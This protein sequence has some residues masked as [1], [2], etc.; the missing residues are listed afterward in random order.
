MAVT[1]EETGRVSERLTTDHV[2]SAAGVPVDPGDALPVELPGIPTALSSRELSYLHW[3]ASTMTGAGRVVELGSFLGGSTAALVHGLAHS[4]AP[5]ERVLAYDMF[6]V[7]ESAVGTSAAFEAWLVQFGLA[8]GASFLDRFK[9]LHRAWLDRIAVR[10]VEFPESV[11]SWEDRSLYPEQSPIELLFVDVAKSW[12]VHRTVMG[13]F[14]AHVLPGGVLVQQDFMDV[15]TPWIP[16][17]MYQLRDVFEPL[18]AVR[19]TPTVSFRCVGDASSVRDGVRSLWPSS[20]YEDRAARESMWSAVL[21]YWEAAIGAVRARFV[22][23]HAAVHAMLVGDEGGSLEHARVYEEWIRSGASSECY[24]TDA[25]S[26]ILVESSVRLPSLTELGAASLVRSRQRHPFGV[27][28]SAVQF[29]P[30]ELRLK[31]WDRVFESL[32][33]AGHHRVALYG[34]GRHTQ[35]LIESML[36][37]A[38]VEV[39]CVLDDA[40]AVSDIGGIPVILPSEAG[41]ALARVTAV[42][43]SS[44]ADEG[45]IADRASELF[46]D[47]K[48]AV[49]RVY[50]VGEVRGEAAHRASLQAVPS[51]MPDPIV[52]DPSDASAVHR[53]RLGLVR[54]R[55]WLDRFVRVY[56]PPAWARGFVP[57]RDAL[58]LWDMVEAV[59]PDFVLEVGTA[60]GVSSATLIGA[61]HALVGPESSLLTC[62]TQAS[63][64]FD[65]AR[66]VG[67]A[68]GEMVPDLSSRVTVEPYSNA[69]DAA[70]AVPPG[71]ISF[72]FIDA[73]HRHPEPVIDLL[74]LS[75]VLAPGAWVVLH[76]IQLTAVSAVHPDADWELATGA[77]RL[78]HGWPFERVCPEGADPV[79]RN[80]G[81]IRMPPEL[82]AALSVLLRLL[83]TACG[84]WEAEAAAPDVRSVVERAVARAD[85]TR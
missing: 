13:V 5:D 66:P 43:P 38:G 10:P 84:E 6:R 31:I 23:G 36:P 69:S 45:R 74:A 54:E 55:G 59:R 75:E 44:D 80:I 35:W 11:E 85:E 76:D 47:T 41:N 39:V 46:G 8:R 73:N 40:P 83:S 24:V 67:S 61:Q 58:F 77:E 79:E 32:R 2:M 20:R 21:A 37:Q 3:L 64:Y 52:P 62:D 63:C 33:E 53:E 15:Q 68:I 4:A 12:D 28:G 19:G 81:A 16:I 29:C 78:F 50:S 27:A 65:D 9:H 56:R 25:W 18:D 82:G 30:F 72:A 7:P 60:S 70:R 49:W 34:A 17:H 51:V 22:H 26:T 1:A 42:I 48:I 14:G 57:M 71:S